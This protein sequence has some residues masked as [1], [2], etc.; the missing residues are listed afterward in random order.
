MLKRLTKGVAV[1]IENI[2][3]KQLLPYHVN[4]VFNLKPLILL[5][6]KIKKMKYSRLL[7]YIY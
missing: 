2:D 7:I 1:Y 4:N 5:F 6:K 3:K